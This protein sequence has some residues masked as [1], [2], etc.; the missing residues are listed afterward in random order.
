MKQKTL[1][2][3]AAMLAITA[4]T[5]LTAPTAL[6]DVGYP[7]PPPPSTEGGPAAHGVTTPAQ[8][9]IN[10][11]A[12]QPP[13]ATPVQPEI[14]AQ[15]ALQAARQ[16]GDRRGE[17]AALGNLGLAYA[18]LGQPQRAIDYHEQALVISREIGDRRGEGNALG[19]LGNA[20][21]ALGEVERAIGSYEQ[22]LVIGA[23]GARSATIVLVG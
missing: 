16:L 13:P 18:D 10:T 2:G 14:T 6:G 15:A 23:H 3:A 9:G 4:C 21:A 7:P 5:L 22:A 1:A 11:P 20:Y 17:G 8:Q 19:N 12:G